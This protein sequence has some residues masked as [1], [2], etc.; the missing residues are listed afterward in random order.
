MLQTRTSR[1]RQNRLLP[2][3]KFA[4]HT[5]PCTIRLC[6]RTQELTRRA[7]CNF[8][9]L[10]CINQ[11]ILWVVFP[12]RKGIVPLRYCFEGHGEGVTTNTQ[13]HSE[14]GLERMCLERSAKQITQQ[15]VCQ[16][17]T[18]RKISSFST[19]VPSTDHRDFEASLITSSEEYLWV[20]QPLVLS[21]A[22]SAHQGAW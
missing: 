18:G 8:A 19:S 13:R 16:L 15:P 3:T 21:L 5:V 4:E 20:D 11:T 17:A 6:H 2:S 14:L 7:F 10:H 12:G 22:P 9:S 1:T